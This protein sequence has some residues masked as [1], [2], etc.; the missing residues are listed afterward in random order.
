[1]MRSFRISFVL[2]VIFVMA[3]CDRY[4][5]EEIL[6]SR[7]DISLTWKGTEQIVYDPAT[8]QLGYNP[9]HNE[10]RAND[11]NMANYFVLKCKARP[12]TEG[13][14]VGASVEWTLR[15]NVKHYDGLKFEVRRVSP[16]GYVWLWNRS[17]KIG[18]TVKY[19]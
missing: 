5:V 16:D 14:E 11:D 2:A 13:Q 7:E 19:L 9:E 15:T 6:L 1:M 3:S 4:N 18:V 8:W 10:F 17:Q 12:D